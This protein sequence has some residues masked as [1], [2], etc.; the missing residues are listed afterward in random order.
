MSY[1]Y[2]QAKPS[3]IR[4]NA[5]RLRGRT[6]ATA[7]LLDNDGRVDCN[8][9]CWKVHSKAKDIIEGRKHGKPFY[10]V[11]YGAEDSALRECS[12]PMDDR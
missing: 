6:K 2:S 10:P 12:A 5:K 1:T 8:S 11:L 7:F 9:I 4:R 3:I